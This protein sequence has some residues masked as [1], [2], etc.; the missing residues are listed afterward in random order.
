MMKYFF[1]EKFC[2]FYE[3]IFKEKI[4][5]GVGIFVKNLFLVAVGSGFAT[6]FAF[7]FQI[8]AGRFLGPAEYGKYALVQS[9]AM[10][11]YIPM[12]FGINTALVKYNAENEDCQRQRKII[13][14]VFSIVLV[15]S[16][17]SAAAILF[18][19][20][21]LAKLFSVSVQII[22]LALVFCLFYVPY[23][24]LT[25]RLQSLHRM[26]RYS[27]FQACYGFLA[28]AFLLLFFFNKEVNFEA[29]VLSVCFSFFA[30]SAMII[31]S[32]RDC[33]SFSV[34][35]YWVKKI[36]RYGLYSAVGGVAA[37]F[38]TNIDKILINKYMSIAQTGIYRVYYG[39]FITL[40]LS[41]FS[42]FNTV[43]FPAA[44]RNLNKNNLFKKINKVAPYLLVFGLPFLMISGFI[45]IKLYGRQYPF[46]FSLA[47]LFS[48][49]AILI[50]LDG[51][52]CWLMNSVGVAGVK[53]TAAGAVAL[54]LV[55]VSFNF[56]LIPRIGFEGAV[57]SIILG[58]SASIAVVLSQRKM[59]RTKINE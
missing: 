36:M 13:A 54:A 10:F 16:L 20:P 27:F 49:A 52:Y 24:I 38:Y 21:G 14:A 35:A 59:Y 12:T 58:Y 34:D 48:V 44:S 9:I 32:I 3:K 8:L 17:V 53:V 19:T 51:I 6:V 5:A 31:F 37:I 11:F 42:I 23:V 57:I 29:A 47:A 55:S 7:I 45:V 4:S 18:L 33:L 26:K 2:G 50:C 56:L 28:L 41:V 25:S 1:A 46:D 22:E 30:V 43:F 40:A 15:L 39:A